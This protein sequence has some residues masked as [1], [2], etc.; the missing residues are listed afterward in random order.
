MRLWSV[1]TGKCLFRWEFPTA[2]KRV[3][4]SEDDSQVVC[5][6]EQRMGHQGA[7][8]VFD[9]NPEGDGTQ[10]TLHF[11]WSHP[12]STEEDMHFGVTESK[13]PVSFFNPTGSKAVV[14][15]FAT[16]TLILTGHESG[17][18]ALFD[19]K[20]G[21]EVLNNER[22]HMDVVTDLQLSPDR[23]YFIT[24]SK[25]KTARV[26]FSVFCSAFAS[27]HA[28]ENQKQAVELIARTEADI[29]DASYSTSYMI[30]EH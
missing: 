25:D 11:T 20:T 27:L 24:S 30:R 9:I 22:A 4:F 19:A 15:A 10:R 2:V 12:I 1:Q 7:I 13:E 18:V 21:D 3:A 26:R 16:P 14:C 17:K 23:T 29:A 5:I 28:F 8:R 6:T